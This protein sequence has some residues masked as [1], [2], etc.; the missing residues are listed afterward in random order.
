M[1]SNPG[2]G[3]QAIW[4][5]ILG[6]LL[7]VFGS[8]ILIKP[9]GWQTPLSY[10]MFV[11]ASVMMCNWMLC[12]A[13]VAGGTNFD[14]ITGGCDHSSSAFNRT[15]C[16]AECRISNPLPGQSI[17]DKALEKASGLLGWSPQCT[18]AVTRRA[19]VAFSIFLFFCYGGAAVMLIFWRKNIMQP[20]AAADA[21]PPAGSTAAG[22]EVANGAD[23][24][25]NAV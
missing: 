10:G 17:G 12:A 19:V 11:G 1:E 5:M 15:T 18:L 13:A 3:F 25:A 22:K 2:F 9:E 24:K 16:I 23:A 20:R 14:E 7:A 8:L 4:M 21:E 6:V